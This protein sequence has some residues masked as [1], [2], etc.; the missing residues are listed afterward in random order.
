MGFGFGMKTAA[1]AL[2]CAAM[3]LATSGAARAGAEGESKHLPYYV[4]MDPP[5]VYPGAIIRLQV[6]PPA[7]ATGGSVLV[8]GRRY[9]GEIAEDGLFVAFFAVDIDTLPGPYE[10]SWDV[11][12]RH[13]SRVVTVRAR[14]MDEEG[15]GEKTLTKEDL[16]VEDLVRSNPRL[17]SLWNRVTLQRYWKGA[18]DAPSPGPMTATFA[19]RRT[20]E[21]SLGSPH[22][23]VD[24]AARAGSDV[25]T[26]G[27]GRVAMVAQG[28]GA[29]IVVVDHGLG[30]YTYY[31]GLGEV[32]VDEGQWVKHH[33][34]IG[35]MPEEGRPTLH[36]GVRLAGAEVDPVSLPGINLKVPALSGEKRAPKEEKDRTSDYDF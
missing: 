32:F 27:V 31:F 21:S 20:S 19:M 6:R 15:R 7:G 25:I 36:F 16:K 33:T 9:L 35:A 18:F 34:V 10:L 2:A 23:G 30:L 1:A 26:A 17:V 13:G 28:P 4:A 5:I 3:L 11:G 14:R 8:A 22:T 29:K 12:S 24:L